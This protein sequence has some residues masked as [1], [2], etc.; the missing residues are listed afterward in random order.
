ML[1]CQS[2]LFTVNINCNPSSYLI[3]FQ[4]FLQDQIYPFF[5]ILEWYRIYQFYQLKN[6]LDKPAVR[7]FTN[8][9]FTKASYKIT[10][11]IGDIH[12][13]RKNLSSN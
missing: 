13:Y 7:S 6:V 2:L 8:I 12:L 11:S 9:L 4:V 5:Y 1:K 3:K 10:K